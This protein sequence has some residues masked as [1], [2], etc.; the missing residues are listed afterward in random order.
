[1]KRIT[2]PYTEYKKDLNQ[3]LFKGS[4]K[5]LQELVSAL[6]YKDKASQINALIEL[7]DDDQALLMRFFKALKLD[8]PKS[9]EL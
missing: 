7:I 6:E 4:K 5:A 8:A 3:S 2:M 9:E 1:M